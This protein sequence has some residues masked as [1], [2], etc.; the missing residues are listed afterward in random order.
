MPLLGKERVGMSLTVLPPGE[1]LEFETE[2]YT[3][4]KCGVCHTWRLRSQPVR[5]IVRSSGTSFMCLEHTA[6]LEE[7]PACTC[8]CHDRDICWECGERP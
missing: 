8:H 2:Y 3:D 6:V 5:L 1:V 4:W 7:G